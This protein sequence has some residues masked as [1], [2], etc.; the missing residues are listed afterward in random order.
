MFNPVSPHQR[1]EYKPSRGTI[2]FCSSAPEV[3]HVGSCNGGLQGPGHAGEARAGN[4]E[5]GR[6]GAWKGEVN[7]PA[8]ALLS[9]GQQANKRQ[10]AFSV[11][12]PGA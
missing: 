12:Y 6:Q 5:L 4:W 9:L 11:C 2:A 1:P 10:R 7:F 8:E 3:P